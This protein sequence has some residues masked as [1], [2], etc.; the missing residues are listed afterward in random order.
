MYVYTY[1]C[2]Y[3]YICIHLY[4]YTSAHPQGGLMVAT[5]RPRGLRCPGA[6]QG[7][8]AAGHRGRR[9]RGPAPVPATTS[10]RPFAP[11]L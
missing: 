8:A 11:R 9:P 1:M 7:P 6:L 5:L 10:A 2:N 3:M 4:I